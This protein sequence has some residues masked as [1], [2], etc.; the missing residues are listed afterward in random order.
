MYCDLSWS[1]TNSATIETLGPRIPAEAK[2]LQQCSI[3]GA[4]AT[5]YLRPARYTDRKLEE[6]RRVRVMCCREKL[7][8]E[9]ARV[10]E[11]SGLQRSGCSRA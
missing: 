9:L 3:V 5:I 4:T 10:S 11:L 7:P 6:H 2:P 1:P 8:V